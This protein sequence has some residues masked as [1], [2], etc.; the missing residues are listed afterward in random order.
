MRPCQ[1]GAWRALSALK[2][3]VRPSKRAKAALNAAHRLNQRVDP[4]ALHPAT[5]REPRNDAVPTRLVAWFCGLR[6]RPAETGT[7]PARIGSRVAV[8]VVR[9]PPCTSTGSDLRISTTM[10]D[11][12]QKTKDDQLSIRAK[13]TFGIAILR[14]LP[15]RLATWISPWI[16]SGCSLRATQETF[17]DRLSCRSLRSSPK[18]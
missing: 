5:A 7:R 9:M 12:R 8:S 15:D 2:T 16:W 14:D 13:F 1:A 10:K 18:S 4:I 3:P 6:S 11:L 17:D